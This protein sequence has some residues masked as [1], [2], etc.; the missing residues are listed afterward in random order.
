MYPNWVLIL[1]N[2]MG[3]LGIS[4]GLSVFFKKRKIKTGYYQIAGLLIIG[5]MIDLIVVG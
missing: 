4:I 1:F 2:L 5:I 3:I